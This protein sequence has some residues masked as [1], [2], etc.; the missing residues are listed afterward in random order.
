MFDKGRKR[1]TSI[2]ED[3]EGF[4]VHIRRAYGNGKVYLKEEL[5]AVL[6]EAI[7]EVL[8]FMKIQGHQII[9]FYL[10]KC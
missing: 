3:Y 5:Q 8:P 6:K 2:S 4:Y 9:G 7:I 1:F 10:M